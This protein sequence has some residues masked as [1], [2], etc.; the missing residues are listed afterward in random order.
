MWRRAMRPD[1]RRKRIIRR[2]SRRPSGTT[3][4]SPRNF[5]RRKASASAWRCCAASP[6]GS[7]VPYETEAQARHEVQ[8]LACASGSYGTL[9]FK[10]RDDH[11]DVVLAA[12]LIGALHQAVARRLRVRR[13]TRILRISS[14][15]TISVRPSEQSIR[16][17]PP[18]S[19]ILC[20]ST[21]TLES[22]PP[23]TFVTT[24]R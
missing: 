5:I 6:N 3:T 14:S 12:L 23:T 22:S 17:S 8:N 24:W 4:C 9:L 16:Q 10:P 18:S 21:W 11:S 19:A 2:R 15:E 7:K 13:L 1:R 20:I